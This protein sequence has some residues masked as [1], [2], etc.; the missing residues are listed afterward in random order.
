M[1]KIKLIP[2]DILSKTFSGQ[3][4]GYNK[5]EVESFLEMIANQLEEMMLAKN[6]SI[7]LKNATEPES[8]DSEIP[9]K[10]LISSALIIA[11]QTKKDIIENAKN[12]AENIK[13]SAELKAKKMISDAQQYLNVME[14]EYIN[15]KDKKKDFLL[16]FK[17]EIEILLERINSDPLFKEKKNTE[18]KGEN[19]DQ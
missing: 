19:N 2:A 18:N 4:F 6:E 11:E 15:L 17:S 13:K 9:D 7:S 10:N 16:H 3:M 14:H 12:E 8:M 5:K 1:E